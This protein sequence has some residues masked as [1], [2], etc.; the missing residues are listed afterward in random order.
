MPAFVLWAVLVMN[1]TTFVVFG[2]DK[3]RARRGR[4]RIPEST[5]LL[6]AWATGVIGAWVAVSVF[7]H[8]TRKTSFRVKLAGVTLVNLLWLLLWWWAR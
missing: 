1:V 6:L 3:A 2:V 4:R 7:R 8:K 5:L